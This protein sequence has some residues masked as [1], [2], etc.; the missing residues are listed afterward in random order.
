MNLRGFLKYLAGESSDN[1]RID[2]TIETLSE[3]DKYVSIKIKKI[4]SNNECGQDLS[5]FWD[6]QIEEI[7]PFLSFYNNIKK[8]LPEKFPKLLKNIALEL[9]NRLESP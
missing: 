4:C 6:Y 3:C 2:K 5:K 9:Q 8:V 1:N 7:F